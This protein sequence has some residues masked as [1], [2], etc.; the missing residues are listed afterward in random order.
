[1]ENFDISL[2]VNA[3]TLVGGLFVICKLL[4]APIDKRIDRLEDSFK[5]EIKEVKAN[6]AKLEAGQAKLETELAKL[7]TEIKSI[8]ELVQLVLKQNSKTKS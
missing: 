8:K 3:V 4:I 6:Q 5:T 7:E 2:L 1:M